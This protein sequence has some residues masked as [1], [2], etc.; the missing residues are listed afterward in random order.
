MGDGG[1]SLYVGRMKR[2]AAVLALLALPVPASAAALKAATVGCSAQADA[3]KLAALQGRKAA[4]EAAAQPL[5]ASRACVAFAKGIIVDIDE[6]K[7]PL[8][9]IRL[10]GD[11]S[12]YWIAAA[13]V[14]E[15]PGEKGGGGGKKGG[16]G[17]RGH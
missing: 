1:G 11:L 2:A 15:H 6:A 16:G 17:R 5:E 3:T 10:T 14:D 8:A 7:P 4:Q 13:L 12:C 9:C